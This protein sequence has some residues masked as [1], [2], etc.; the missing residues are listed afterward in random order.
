MKILLLIVFGSLTLVACGFGAGGN[1]PGITSDP[2]KA[3]L[4]IYPSAPTAEETLALKEEGKDFFTA[5]GC[6]SCHST[7]GER[8]SLQGPPLAGTANRYTQRNDGDELEARRWMVKHIKQPQDFPGVFFNT[9]EYPNFM[10]PNR[11]ITDADMKA[12]VE[13]LWSLG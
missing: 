13:F 3:A 2:D 1:Q 7:T 9:E 5:F 6:A 10:P 11:N 4:A 8:A 12:L